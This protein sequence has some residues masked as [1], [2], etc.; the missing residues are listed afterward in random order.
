MCVCVCVCI[1]VCVCV[2]V[3][4]N[5][6]C[7]SLVCTIKDTC[8]GSFFFIMHFIM[9]FTLFNLLRQLCRMYIL[10]VLSLQFLPTLWLHMCFSFCFCYVYI[11]YICV[12][13]SRCLV[14]F[15]KLRSLCGMVHFPQSWFVMSSCSAFAFSLQFCCTAVFILFCCCW[16]VSFCY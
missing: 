12:V 5:L 8:L 10:I 2:H 15:E 7:S 16:S 9:H 13:D 3:C 6:D 14:E 11:F 1:I 4:M